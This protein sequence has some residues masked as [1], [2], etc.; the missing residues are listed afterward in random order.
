[1]DVHLQSNQL[2]TDKSY[3]DA[4]ATLVEH[5]LHPDGLKSSFDDGQVVHRVPAGHCLQAAKTVA[6]NSKEDHCHPETI[7]EVDPFIIHVG[8]EISIVRGDGKRSQQ[9]SGQ[10]PLFECS[11]DGE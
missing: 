7:D 5:W 9:L 4:Q 11:H 10:E 6:C 8:K 3:S 1:M 2:T